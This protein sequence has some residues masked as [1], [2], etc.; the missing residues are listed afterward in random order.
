MKLSAFFRLSFVENMFCF[1]A[2]YVN[3]S[4]QLFSKRLIIQ[5]YI[6]YRYNC[7]LDI[8]ATQRNVFHKKFPEFLGK[9]GFLHKN[10][11]NLEF[12]AQRQSSCIQ[13]QFHMN[14]FNLV[15]QKIYCSSSQF[16]HFL[17]YFCRKF[18]CLPSNGQKSDLYCYV[19]QSFS[20]LMEKLLGARF[21]Q[22][23][24][25]VFVLFFFTRTLGLHRGTFRQ[26]D[27]HQQVFFRRRQ[28]H[29]MCLTTK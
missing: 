26:Y 2:V 24:F 28:F 7:F 14:S 18:F 27:L 16:N 22:K 6:G 21:A 13:K 20:P 5:L 29:L 9:H 15:K 3:F 19:S 10:F 17:I 4:G 23:I 25:H 1:L 12:Y 8:G 11:Q